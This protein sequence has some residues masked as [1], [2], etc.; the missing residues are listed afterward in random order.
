[1]ADEYQDTNASQFQAYPRAG[2]AQ[3]LCVVGDD[4]QSIYGWRGA[5][6]G[7]LLDLENF[8]PKVEIVKLEQGYRSAALHSSTRPTPSSKTT[9]AAV[10]QRWSDWRGEQVYAACLWER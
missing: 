9:P 1:M 3:N 8:Y 10:K 4:D 7:N 6:I 5:E 2:G